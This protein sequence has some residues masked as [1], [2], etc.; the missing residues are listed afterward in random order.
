MPHLKLDQSLIDEA[1]TLAQ[2]IVNP[3]IE[4]IDGHTTVAIERATGTWQRAAQLWQEYHPARV[5]VRGRHRSLHASG[6]SDQCSC[7]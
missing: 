6:R 2:H 4:Y 3:V 1:R 5:V 7:L